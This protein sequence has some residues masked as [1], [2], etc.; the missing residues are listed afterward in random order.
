MT[1]DGS[2]VGL[3]GENVLINEYKVKNKGKTLY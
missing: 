1:G 3:L 2:V